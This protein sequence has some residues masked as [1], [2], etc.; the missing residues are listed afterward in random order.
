[1]Q[2]GRKGIFSFMGSF[3]G[4]RAENEQFF[5]RKICD[6]RNDKVSFLHYSKLC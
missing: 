5:S 3:A 6:P 1:V 4:W 2:H